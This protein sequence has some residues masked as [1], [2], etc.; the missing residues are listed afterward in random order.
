MIKIIL[1]NLKLRSAQYSNMPSRAKIVTIRGGFLLLC[2]ISLALHSSSAQNTEPRRWT[3][4]PLGTNAI[5]AGYEYSFGELYLDPL[6][7]VEDVTFSVNTFFVT[8]LHPFRIGDKL[9]R[10][11][12]VVP[13][14]IGDWQGLVQGVPAAVNRTG[15][16]DPRIRLTANIV[17]PPASEA[18]EYLEFYKENPVFTTIGASISVSLPLGKYLED[19]LINLGQNLFVITPQLG[20]LH[21]WNQWSAEGT[22]SVNFFTNNNNFDSGKTKNQRPTSSIQTH[23]TRD[24]KNG[25]SASAGIGYGLSG[26]SV[27]NGIPN[28]DN[29]Y[30]IQ[31]AASFG[32]PIA[33]KQVIQVVYIRS[34]TLK[35]IG[36]DTN[37]F[38]LAYSV[39]F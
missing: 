7:E 34:Q 25:Y 16:A 2:Y 14:N 22:L 18:K 15:F 13:F 1:S 5:A 28:S 32:F 21:Q 37:S 11:D 35:D 17:G 29:R 39:L 19:E 33:K 24:F 10:L 23:L 4:L 31:A 6:I 26:Q 3:P 12:V 30:D 36:S 20:V 9:A 27:V 8:Y 38:A